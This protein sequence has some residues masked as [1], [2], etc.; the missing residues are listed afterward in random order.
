MP[1]YQ[2]N[3]TRARTALL[4]SSSPQPTTLHVILE[5]SPEPM[6]TASGVIPGHALFDTS[7]SDLNNPERQQSESQA[8]AI[9]RSSRV[10][11]DTPAIAHHHN[12]YQDCQQVEAK[13]ARRQRRT[14]RQA[15]TA[16]GGSTTEQSAAEE[17]VQTEKPR[18]KRHKSRKSCKNKKANSGSTT[19][20]ST[21]DASDSE[22]DRSDSGVH[23][24]A[25]CEAPSGN[26]GLHSPILHRAGL[27][28]SDVPN[29]PG[30]GV[31]QVPG[32]PIPDPSTHHE[33]AGGEP[34]PDVRPDVT[35]SARPGPGPSSAAN[36]GPGPG[37]SPGN[38]GSRGSGSH[39]SNSRDQALEHKRLVDELTRRT[40]LKVFAQIPLEVLK[41]M[42]QEVIHD[43]TLE[44]N[45]LAKNP[46]NVGGGHHIKIKQSNKP[47][48]MARRD[49]NTDT[50]P[51][52][53]ENTNT[54]PKIDTE[55]EIQIQQS[56]NALR[57]ERAMYSPSPLPNSH[58]PID[59]NIIHQLDLPINHACETLGT[60]QDS[61][62][63]SRPASQPSTHRVP[64]VL[65]PGT[66]TQSQTFG[67]WEPTGSVS[68]GDP[69]NSRPLS[70]QSAAS[71]SASRP[72]PATSTLAPTP[73]AD[74]RSARSDLGNLHAHGNRGQSRPLDDRRALA[75]GAAKALREQ[76]AVQAP[77]PSNQAS[78]SSR[79][80]GMT[81]PEVFVHEHYR[82]Q[83]ERA[84][85]STSNGNNNPG[86][87][88][89]SGRRA[90]SPDLM[91]D[92]EEQL[93]AAAAQASGREPK[94]RRKKK[95]AARDIHGN[96]RH[97]LTI[98]KQHLF[99]Y[100]LTEGAWQ[101][102]GLVAR[103]SSPV[104]IKTWGQELP[105]VP[106]EP[107]SPETVQI[108]VN[109]LAT[110][111]GRVKDVL[112]PF[113]QYTFG[114][115]KPALTTEAI[116][117]N[118]A[119]FR[120]IHPNRFH[121]LEYQPAYGHYE[122]DSLSQAIAVA[123]FS[124]PTSVGVTFRNYFDP[125]PLTTVAFVLA[126][127]QF[128]IEE[129]ETGQF[130]PHDL[131]AA[132]MLNKYVAH[133]RGLKEARAGAKTRMSRMQGEWFDYGFEYS[134]TMTVDD[135]FTQVITLR[136]EIRPD[137]PP[138]DGETEQPDDFLPDDEPEPEPEESEP[139]NGRYSKR[140]KGKGR[141]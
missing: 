122:S 81:S 80:Y 69:S 116:N 5:S 133:L 31:P 60:T 49:T 95:P 84:Q 30:T 101:N 62:Q 4:E 53:N 52:S 108:M 113:T 11:I 129:Y 91:S 97:I 8:S 44:A 24:V 76:H 141:A 99:A 14:S 103:W 70:Q 36:S 38:S 90:S 98:A 65:V 128:C 123:L 75:K 86:E 25:G 100:V 41:V 13:Q 118:L 137:T 125:M 45:L 48:S 18:R 58:V 21:H 68:L 73:S 104:Y 47:G 126:N 79:P 71:L 136:S 40:G 140:A 64:K 63:P 132:D 72:R 59:P 15:S 67:P 32:S 37:S 27:P 106:V 1:N 16:N 33:Q 29:A 87:G 121:C 135:P 114:F 28:S 78:G 12:Y 54:E 115:K 96:E 46:I 26:G 3:N 88:V 92:N 112:R 93:A 50:E 130:Q 55:P 124:S 94:R 19:E 127:V 61:T 22:P 35:S 57:R 109:S 23:S 83:R 74:S 7:E 134:G 131:N 119:I 120:E 9:R 138:A 82:A 77:G 39:N 85:A 20:Q 117:R 51:S 102:R 139:E 105:G 66:Q 107:P 111:R 6:T 2:L 42:L 34:G 56:A 43:Q 17:D 10:H 110:A 89:A